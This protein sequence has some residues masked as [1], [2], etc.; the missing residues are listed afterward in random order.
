M[1]NLN[2]RLSRLEALSGKG[3]LPGL[4][5]VY[6]E[7]SGSLIDETG[8]PVPDDIDFFGLQLILYSLPASYREITEGEFTGAKSVLSF[9]Q[10]YE[11][12]EQW[13]D[14][15]QDGKR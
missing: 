1:R 3:K 7:P 11:T 10:R 2:A 6:R 14:S 15:V 13:Q 9:P 12:P 5:I 8:Q 4:M